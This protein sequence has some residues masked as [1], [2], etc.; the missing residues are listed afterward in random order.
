MLPRFDSTSCRNLRIMILQMYFW[1]DMDH[2]KYLK[3]AIIFFWSSLS[4]SLVSVVSLLLLVSPKCFSSGA[5]FRLLPEYFSI[6]FVFVSCFSLQDLWALF[7]AIATFTRPLFWSIAFR[8][9][10]SCLLSLKDYC[11]STWNLIDSL[12]LVLQFL[13][14][15]CF[16][17]LHLSSLQEGW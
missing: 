6:F 13:F 10:I 16:L 9:L 2:V 11:F 3:L 1:H 17:L 15:S 8:N 4:S 7:R 5:V 12:V 14:S